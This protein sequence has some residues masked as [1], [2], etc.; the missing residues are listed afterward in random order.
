MPF[1]ASAGVPPR[2]M[3]IGRTAGPNKPT[4]DEW[5]DDDFHLGLMGNGLTIIAIPG[6]K[7][8]FFRATLIAFSGS[9]WVVRMNQWGNEGEQAMLV[10]EQASQHHVNDRLPQKHFYWALRTHMEN[11]QVLLDIAARQAMES[12]RGL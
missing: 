5:I 12:L 7:L 8:A 4:N 10:L 3:G 1:M 9:T 11:P 6:T 2:I